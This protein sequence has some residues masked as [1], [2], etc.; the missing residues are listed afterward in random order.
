MVKN[1]SIA[2]MIFKIGPLTIKRNKR[3]ENKMKARLAQ[4]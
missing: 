2:C 3:N 4:D 1:N